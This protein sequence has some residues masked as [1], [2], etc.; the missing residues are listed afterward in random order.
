M[1]IQISDEQRRALLEQV[2][3]PVEVVDPQTQRAYVLIPREEYQRMQ[4]EPDPVRGALQRCEAITAEIPP[5]IRRS[6][7]AYWR[8]LPT[9]LPKVSRKRQWV[10]Y[11]GDEQIGFGRTQ[12]ELY[13]ECYRRGLK[14]DG[15]YIG[16]LRPSELAPWEPDIVEA[17]YAYWDEADDQDP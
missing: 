10:A 17:M 3:E 16:R 6:Q 15:F 11:H 8:E 4:L 14:E 5:G 13:Q 12:T 1:S 9:L 2:D 7:E